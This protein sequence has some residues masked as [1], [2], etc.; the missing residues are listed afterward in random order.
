[1]VTKIMWHVDCIVVDKNTKYG[2]DCTYIEES[3]VRSLLYS[4]ILSVILPIFTLRFSQPLQRVHGHFFG[5][6]NNKK[7]GLACHIWLER[8]SC[9][10]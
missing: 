4:G 6:N 9:V 5:K 1:M 10:E 2:E 8:S 3:T 7:Q